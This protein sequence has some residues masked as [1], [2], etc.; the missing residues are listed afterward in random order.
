M[1]QPGVEKRTGEHSIE[2]CLWVRPDCHLQGHPKLPHKPDTNHRSMRRTGCKQNA[3]G[4]FVADSF[5]SGGTRYPSTASREILNARRC[6]KMQSLRIP[7]KKM[8]MPP[9]SRVP[10]GISWVNEVIT[11]SCRIMQLSTC[12]RACNDSVR[13]RAMPGDV[14]AGF[15]AATCPPTLFCEP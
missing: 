6:W 5:H 9:N 10:K 14:G 7:N 11:A 4:A 3:A 12:I 2:R 1:H 15:R 13:L 8:Q